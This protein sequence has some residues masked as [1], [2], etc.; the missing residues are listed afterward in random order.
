MAQTSCCIFSGK[1]KVK[2]AESGSG[3]GALVSSGPGIKKEPSDTRT[4]P[5]KGFVPK[6]C[7]TAGMPL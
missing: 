3:R 2:K 6:A 1:I 4:A 5:F 7:L